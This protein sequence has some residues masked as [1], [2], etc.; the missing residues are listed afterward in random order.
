MSY[1]WLTLR[2]KYYVLL[3]GL[4]LGVPFYLLVLHDW[5]KLTPREY[6]HYQRQFFGTADDPSRFSYAWNNHQKSNRHHWEYWIPITGHSKGGYKDLQPLPMP[7]KYVLEMVADWMGASRAYEGNWLDAR[8]WSW[9]EKKE[10][11]ILTRCHQDTIRYIKEALKLLQIRE[12]G[13]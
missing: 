12:Q 7:R 5:S 2:H 10:Q 9:W 6:P 13:V 8:G 3:A 1:F 4:K 11:Y